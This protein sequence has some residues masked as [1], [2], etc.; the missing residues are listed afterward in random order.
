MPAYSSFL[1]P[2][3]VFPQNLKVLF[4][5]KLL[6]SIGMQFDTFFLPYFL[7]Q[8]GGKFQFFPLS[9][10]QNGMIIVGSYFL[11]FR[12]VV[13]LSSLGTSRFIRNFGVRNSMILSQALYLVLLVQ[14]V[15]VQNN[16]IL[17]VPILI[18]EGIR[19][20]LFWIPYFGLFSSEAYYK[21]MGESVGTIEFF[22][23][24]IQAAIPAISGFIIVT[25]GFSYLFYISML[26]QVLAIMILFSLH[27]KVQFSRASLS[28]LQQWLQEPQYRL[29][30]LS[31]VGK[32]VADA[33][34]TLW[35]LFVL[36][37]IGTADKVGFLYFVVF[38]VSLLLVYFSGWFVDHSKSRRPLSIS[39]WT[40]GILWIGR[41]L[42]SSVW[43]I[44]AVDI[45]QK[46][47]ESVYLPFYDSLMLRRSK[48]KKAISYFIYRE[49][50]I[51]ATGIIFWSAFIV[52]FI[53]SDSWRSFVLIGFVG[54]LMSMQL[55]DKSSSTSG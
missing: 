55:R 22:T 32:Y 53:V 2:H 43:T 46:L 7:Y 13:L 25:L 51:S 21:R 20:P 41:A 36:L 28:E 49:M 31:F 15:F 8:L 39:G 35:P 9:E 37:L 50:I 3:H 23:R 14:L 44:I 12:V 16:P 10:F 11:F 45:F 30:S 40:M 54:A 42:V 34:Q 38:F 48:G 26:F 47:A 33:M 5:V 27:E 24:L 17:F 4:V 29:L 18:I 1:H 6:R 52:F 19:I